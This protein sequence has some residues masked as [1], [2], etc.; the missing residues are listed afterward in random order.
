MISVW[1]L[2]FN[3]KGWTA[4]PGQV[5]LTGNDVRATDVISWLALIGQHAASDRRSVGR[6]DPSELNLRQGRAGV[7]WLNLCITEINKFINNNNNNTFY[8]YSA[9]QSRF[10]ERN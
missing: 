2:T 8:L 9:F 4:A 1:C 6:A 7:I 10:N 3:T 5:P